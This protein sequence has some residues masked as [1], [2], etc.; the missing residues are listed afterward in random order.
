MSIIERID[1]FT[2]SLPNN[3]LYCA[4]GDVVFSGHDDLIGDHL[5]CMFHATDG[6][7]SKKFTGVPKPNRDFHR[8]FRPIMN[9][10]ERCDSFKPIKFGGK[11]FKVLDHCG[12]FDSYWKSGDSDV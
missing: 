6:L 5:A 1:M 4:Y 8:T 11:K 7:K 12:L 2:M 9:W 3:C 10:D